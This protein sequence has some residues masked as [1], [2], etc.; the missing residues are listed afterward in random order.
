MSVVMS[1]CGHDK[2]LDMVVASNFHY[3]SCRTCR[4]PRVNSNS[5]LEHTHK[6]TQKLPIS[7]TADACKSPLH[8]YLALLW[9]AVQTST[10]WLFMVFII[11]GL[12][13]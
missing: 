3:G 6:K 4:T 1:S 2:S 9:L 8:P 11:L 10:F 13:V 7:P 5:S 12:E